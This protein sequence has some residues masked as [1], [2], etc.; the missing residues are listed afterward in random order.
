M[1]HTDPRKPAWQAADKAT[2][3]AIINALYTLRSLDANGEATLTDGSCD[4]MDATEFLETVRGAI[5]YV[6]A[7]A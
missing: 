3:Q 4:Q 2:S 5:A 7:N 6:K 1:Q